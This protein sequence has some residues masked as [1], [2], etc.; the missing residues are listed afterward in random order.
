VK[1]MGF[2]GTDEEL[3]ERL[4]RDGNAAAGLLHDR[5][6]AEVNGLVWRLLGPDNDHDDIVQ[7]VFCRLLLHVGKVRESD[8]L[9]SWV[10]S[11]TV[12]AVYSEL[13]KRS[14][15]RVFWKTE[16]SKP[17]PYQD[18]GNDVESRD[19]LQRVYAELELM[20]AAERVAFCLRYVDG[21]QLAEVAELCDCSL[22]TIK[23]RL[24]K[25]EA[26]LEPLRNS[27]EELER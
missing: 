22:A 9:S 5:F 4:H 13:R 12:N 15:R 8:R 3:L 20:P 7:T 25:A 26:K 16:S 14:V 27:F 21:K 24:Q 10:R 11:I 18:G 1:L 2:R 23:R 17:E 6:S 19:L